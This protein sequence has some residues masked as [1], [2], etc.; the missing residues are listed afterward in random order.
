VTPSHDEL[1]ATV[2]TTRPAPG[3]RPDAMT[4]ALVRPVEQATIGWVLEDPP[5][6]RPDLLGEL[7]VLVTRGPEG[8]PD[9]TVR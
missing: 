2:L 9:G 4:W 8:S 7:S 3:R 1:V 5:I 6:A